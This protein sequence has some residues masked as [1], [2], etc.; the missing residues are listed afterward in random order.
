MA[1]KDIII[2]RQEELRRLYIIRQVL[3]KKLQQV[4]A[5]EKLNLS[6]R[7]MTRITK[8]VKDQ[9]DSGIIHKSRGQPSQRE[10]SAKTKSKVIIFCK[11]KYTGFG[12][13]LASEKLFELEDIK[14]SK[15]TLRAWLIKE[16]L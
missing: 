11:N 9:G 5:A 4:E 12:P 2:L 6:Y 14:I 13:T 3:D 7:Q 1:G 8:R 16:G 10:I 15:E